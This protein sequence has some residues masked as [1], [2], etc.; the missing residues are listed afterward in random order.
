MSAVIPNEGEVQLLTEQLSAGENWLLG[1]FHSNITPAETDTAATYTAQEATFSGYAR[2]T[3]TRSVSGSTWQVTSGAPSGTPPWSAE[4][5][6]AK[7]SYGSAAQVWTCGLTGDTVYGYFIV[8]MSSGKLILAEAFS[9]PRTL[10][11]G[12]TLTL[13]P[14][15]EGA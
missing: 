8:G 4:A 13:P 2:K 3:L 10:A 1:L 12:D 9:T 11:A 6:V 7:G 15:F 5:S 14:V